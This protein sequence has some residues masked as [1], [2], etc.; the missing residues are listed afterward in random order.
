[1][2]EELHT[3]RLESIWDGGP[4]GGGTLKGEGGSILFGMPKELG[5]SGGRANPEELLISAVAACYSITLAILAERRRLPIARIEVAAEGDVVRQ[6]G[7]TL[8]F[9]AIRLKPRITVTGGDEGT[10]SAVLDS[11]HKADT[12]CVISNAVRGSV[13]LSVSPEIVQA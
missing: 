2:A 3:F 12:Y 10:R 9:A 8:K 1:M 7:G 6:L 11:A 5:G 13:E 4:D